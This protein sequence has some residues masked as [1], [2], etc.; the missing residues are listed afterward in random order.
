[1]KG[2]KKMV[3]VIL[4]VTILAYIGWAIHK[5]RIKKK[6]GGCCGGSCSSC[7]SKKDCI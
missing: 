4:V 6:N 3:T 7:V 5:I 2:R 1:M